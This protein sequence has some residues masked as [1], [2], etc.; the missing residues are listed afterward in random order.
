M[1]TGQLSPLKTYSKE[2]QYKN[3]SR[4]IFYFHKNICSQNISLEQKY[5]IN[6]EVAVL[7]AAA[8]LLP[9]K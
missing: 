6:N 9:H 1:I 5:A 7:E 8:I 4:Q 3:M 2:L